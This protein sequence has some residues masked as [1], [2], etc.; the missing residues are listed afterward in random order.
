MRTLSGD[1]VRCKGCGG[2]SVKI[3]E[4]NFGGRTI[5]CEECGCEREIDVALVLGMEDYDRDV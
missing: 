1:I 4:K 3:R 2:S 5:W